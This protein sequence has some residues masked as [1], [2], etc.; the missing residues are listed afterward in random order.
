[1]LPSEGIIIFVIIKIVDFNEKHSDSTSNIGEE[2]KVIF[3]FCKN[4][5]KKERK[6]VL[7]QTICEIIKQE[8]LYV[9]QKKKS[10][11]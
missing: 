8:F 3:N 9:T 7:L 1:M 5:V 10:Y 2:R 11:G 4:Y 6:T